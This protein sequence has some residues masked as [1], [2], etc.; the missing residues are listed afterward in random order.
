MSFQCIIL[1]LWLY[2]NILACHRITCHITRRMFKCKTHQRERESE[3]LRDEWRDDRREI[4]LTVYTPTRNP[5]RN[6]RCFP[7]SKVRLWSH[8][9]TGRKPARR[10]KID[11]TF[12][13]FLKALLFTT[14]ETSFRYVLAYPWYAERAYT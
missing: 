10:A 9:R 12:L 1:T 11:V 8:A 7:C 5:T 2:Y 3:Y 13:T 4:H 6:L 14:I